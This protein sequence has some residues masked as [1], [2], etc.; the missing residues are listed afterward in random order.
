MRTRNSASMRLYIAFLLFITFFTSCVSINPSAVQLSSEVGERIVEM[1]KLHRLAVQ[2]Y[3][4]GERKRIEDY[5]TYVWEPQYLKNLLGMSDVLQQLQAAS[6]IDLRTK[7]ILQK[8]IAAYLLDTSEA[9]RAATELVK[10]L[11]DARKGERAVVKGVL[12]N[13]IENKKLDSAATHITALLGSDE[14]AQII[15]EFAAAAHKEMQAQRSELLDPLE[16][17]RVEAMET[18]GQAYSELIRGHSTITGRL[19]A[20]SKRTKQQDELLGKL[21][22][23]KISQ[24]LATKL[25]DVSSKVNEGLRQA[26]K[27]IE[28]SNGDPDKIFKSLKDS[29]KKKEDKK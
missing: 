22:I 16:A 21:G 20:A 19:E 2:R 10:K 29:L 17:L 26:D 11:T 28:D 13:F 14:P 8:G 9:E 15:L 4:D 7:N 25:A 24:D 12:T 23:G 1:E 5:L 27:I 6:V 3:F 18:L